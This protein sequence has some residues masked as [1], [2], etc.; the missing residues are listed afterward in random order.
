MAAM[1]RANIDEEKRRDFSLYVDEFQNFSTDSIATILSEARK[2]RLS[3]VLANQFIGQLDDKIRDAIFG[4]VGSLMSFRTGPE[5]AEFMTKQFT[6]Q[7][8]MSDMVNIPNYTAVVKMIAD[9]APTTPFTLKTIYA[10]RA[11]DMA[12]ATA[13]RDLSRAKYGHP[14]AEIEKEIFESL[15]IA[16]EAGA[17]PP[18]APV[19]NR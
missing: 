17:P 14:K 7:F 1:S 19:L 2:Y 9:G 15:K 16:T 12:V 3:L 13:I 5:D 8:D 6:P 10:P 11:S 18:P 4:N